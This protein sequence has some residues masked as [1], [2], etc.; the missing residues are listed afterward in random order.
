MSIK[1]IGALVIGQS[2]RPDLVAPLVQLLPDCEIRQAGALDG[3]TPED[4]PGTTG[5]GKTMEQE[6]SSERSAG[7]GAG[8]IEFERLERSDGQKLVA[9]FMRGQFIERPTKGKPSAGQTRPAPTYKRKTLRRE[10][11]VR[12]DNITQSRWCELALEEPREELYS[13]A[14]QRRE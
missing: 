8:I 11:G 4:L 9:N 2:P 10:G 7:S 14:G 3:L 6:I 5:D 1:R 12:F 13:N